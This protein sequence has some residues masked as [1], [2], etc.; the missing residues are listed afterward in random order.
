MCLSRSVSTES[1]HGD[2]MTFTAPYSKGAATKRQRNH[3]GS[4]AAN[5]LGG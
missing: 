4:I 2:D 1:K 5:D 3:V